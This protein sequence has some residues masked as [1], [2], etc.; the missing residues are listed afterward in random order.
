MLQLTRRGAVLSGP[1]DHLERLCADYERQRCVRLRGL[2]EPGLLKTIQDGIDQAEFVAHRH[3]RLGAAAPHDLVMT[4]NGSAALLQFL[5]NDPAFLK[6]VATI[7]GIGVAGFSGTVRR[8][9]PGSFDAWHNDVVDGRLL[10]MTLNLSREVFQGG[11]LQ[12][13]NWDTG[14][15]L[16]EIANTGFGDAVLFAI[17][18]SL[19]HRI[20]NV[21]GT[22]PR[23]IFTGF[24]FATPLFPKPGTH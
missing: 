6:A 4:H 12:L 13:R 3:D 2:I 9:V 20:T 21:E 8:F 10:A 11:V 7:T 19:K 15:D 5:A 22:V 17:D 18:E 16:H 14:A 23:T 24:F 1:A